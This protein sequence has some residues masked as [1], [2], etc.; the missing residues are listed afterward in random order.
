MVVG[1][2][3]DSHGEEFKAL[4]FFGAYIV[5]GGLN[6]WG[7]LRLIDILKQAGFGEISFMMT[8]GRTGMDLS[9]ECYRAQYMGGTAL[10]KRRRM[11]MQPNKR[12][13]RVW[14]QPLFPLY[15]N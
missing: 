8:D 3:R 14:V 1:P 15:R 7:F 12:D 11:I 2:L 6:E 5:E 10:D 13:H 9:N 4:S